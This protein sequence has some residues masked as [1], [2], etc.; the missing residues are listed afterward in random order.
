MRTTVVI[1]DSKGRRWKDDELGRW[2]MESQLEIDAERRDEGIR[3][4]RE[5][6]R[7]VHEEL[8]TA[9]P[10]ERNRLRRLAGAFRANIEGW[11]S[12]GRRA[13]ADRRR[14]ASGE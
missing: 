2:A 3:F 5:G 8:R 11:H 14:A 13:L 7:K 9:A 6:L 1:T 10:G 4:N 12:E